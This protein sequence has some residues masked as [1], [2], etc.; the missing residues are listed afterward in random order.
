M[1]T[2]QSANS[3]IDGKDLGSPLATAHMHFAAAFLF[4]A[5]YSVIFASA[6]S[7]GARGLHRETPEAH[8]VLQSFAWVVGSGIAISLASRL[9]KTHRL[10]VGICSSLVSASFGIAL[11][12]FFRDDLD[13]AVVDTVFGHSFSVRHYLVGFSLLSLMVGFV[14]AFFGASSH[15]DED[16]TAQL[17]AVPSRH[18]LWLW[19]VGF[20]WVNILP[21]VAYYIWLQFA[22]AVYSV[23]HP[24]LW[25]QVGTDVF[26]GFLGIAALVKG[27][28]VSLKA[29]SEKKSYGGVM[30][31]RVLV[32][33]AGGL[34]LACL[35]APVLLNIDIERMKE[36]PASLGSHPW[37]IL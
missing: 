30:W 29:V 4:G 22:T 27:I 10:A 17:L 28:E 19:I 33:L 34:V 26:F 32:F 31:K 12:L 8:G 9:S 11:I 1:E 36:L 18:W 20:G 23:I 14:G 7:A 25:F 6:M 2:E 15:D 35:V 3:E 5:W 37:W 13:Q 24:S 16:L 21:I